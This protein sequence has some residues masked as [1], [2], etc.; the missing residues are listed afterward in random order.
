MSNTEAIAAIRRVLKDY[1]EASYT[2]DV[3]LLKTTFHPEALMSGFLEDE[4]YIGSPEPFYDDLQ[5]NPSSKESGEAYRA[6]VAFIHVDGPVASA[7]IV[8]DSLLGM[9]YVNHFHLLKIQGEW[10]IISKIYTTVA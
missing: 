3:P 7:A 1:M 10:K 8:E 2:A 4:L 9:N 6:Q 5:D